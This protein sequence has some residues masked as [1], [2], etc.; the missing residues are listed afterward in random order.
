MSTSNSGLTQVSVLK[1]LGDLIENNISNLE[2]NN[3]KLIKKLENID[4][5]IFTEN[6][7][8]GTIVDG[9]DIFD[10][11]FCYNKSDSILN[12]W[13]S[14]V[15]KEE[16]VM[17]LFSTICS[18]HDDL[19][20][21]HQGFNSAI[22]DRDY[23]LPERRKAFYSILEMVK[24]GVLKEQYGEITN[25][26]EFT[27]KTNR[28]SLDKL[29]ITNL[30]IYLEH[31]NVNTLEDEVRIYRSLFKGFTVLYLSTC[32]VNKLE[33]SNVSNLIGN[34]YLKSL[35]NTLLSDKEHTME[36]LP[37]CNM[38][39]SYEN[40]N[41]LT[42]LG[43]PLNYGLTQEDK[44][45]ISN[46]IKYL[47]IRNSPLKDI[48][49]LG[50]TS[51]KLYYVD[52]K[53]PNLDRTLIGNELRANPNFVLVVENKD[54]PY[55]STFIDYLR[56]Y[57][58]QL[59]FT[60]KD[61]ILYKEQVSPDLFID[62][63]INTDSTEL[64]SSLK[65][66]YEDLINECNKDYFNSREFVD[67]VILMYKKGIII[68]PEGNLKPEHDLIRNRLSVIYEQLKSFSKF[69]LFRQLEYFN[70]LARLEDGFTITYNLELVNSLVTGVRVGSEVKCKIKN[71]D[72]SKQ[73]V[74]ILK[75]KL[76]LEDSE[77]S[78]P[79]KL[80]DEL[81]NATQVESS[82][83]TYKHLLETSNIESYKLLSSK[84]EN[85]TNKFKYSIDD[86]ANFIDELFNLCYLKY[87]QYT[88]NKDFDFKNMTVLKGDGDALY[89]AYLKFNPDEEGPIIKCSRNLYS[90]ETLPKKFR[91]LGLTKKDG[92]PVIMPG[93]KS[94]PILTT[95]MLSKIESINE[96]QIPI[97]ATF[98]I[99]EEDKLILTKL[100]ENAD[101][102]RS[103]T[104]R[105][106]RDRNG[107]IDMYYILTYKG[108]TTQYDTE[109]KKVFIGEN[110]YISPALSYDIESGISLS[111][112]Y[113]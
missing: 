92:R 48:P 21:I 13:S 52:L 96:N 35:I 87:R 59:S 2:Q 26:L 33:Y 11:G 85:L 41:V 63:K 18:V 89:I 70:Y 8:L 108:A 84:L 80:L 106:I 62:G 72:W 111:L 97:F 55:D 4:N 109:N 6:V 74:T 94:L 86:K 103:R 58:P 31:N 54:F 3:K 102:G 95:N 42:E 79:T 98:G 110:D 32:V 113:I 44:S 76:P 69:P 47:D 5:S 49:F 93:S 100:C 43:N 105:L 34:G 15:G 9:Q 36:F 99:T 112:N 78:S 64:N 81:K 57:K 53:N 46:L 77:S 30:A 24:D 25:I 90:D 27:Q 56:S 45:N 16:E 19:G 20:D 37:D 39:R 51:I 71:Q 38:W 40:Y 75:I 73:H 101:S 88:V 82:T 29:I 7:G 83:I 17:E 60:V 104:E 50:N 12:R 107:E 22:A 67:A 91:K 28:D 61:G 68:E 10:D 14:K 65:I 23:C 1:I 66:H